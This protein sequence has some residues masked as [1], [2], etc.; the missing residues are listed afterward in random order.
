VR[1]QPRRDV[2]V[3][4]NQIALRYAQVR[5]EELAEIRE[6]HDAAVDIHIERVFVFGKFDGRDLIDVRS[7]TAG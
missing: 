6:L 3:I 5:P 4:L 2:E 1:Q 7:T